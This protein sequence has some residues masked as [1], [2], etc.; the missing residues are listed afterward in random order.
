MP[1]D[2]EVL[3]DVRTRQ[4]A[5]VRSGSESGCV[6]KHPDRRTFRITRLCPRTFL[7]QAVDG[8][9]LWYGEDGVTLI[10]RNT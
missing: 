8:G 2:R 1:P 5:C 7:H 4:N 9:G 6:E 3:P 10:S